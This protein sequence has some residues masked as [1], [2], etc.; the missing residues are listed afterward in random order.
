MD[1]EL[2]AQARLAGERLIEAE[3]DADVARADFHRAVRRLHLSGASLRQLAS[4]LKLSH[5]RI[6][7]IVEEAGGARRWRVRD[8]PV[9]GALACSFCG[10]TQPRTKVLVAGPGVWICD[11]CIK[12]AGTVMTSGRAAQTPLGPLSAVPEDVTDRRCSFCG[13]SRYQVSGLVISIDNPVGKS[14]EDASICAECLSLCQEI[15]AE[16]LSSSASSS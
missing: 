15:H 12:R 5:Q 2:L 8:Q 7:Q 16:R 4:E 14:G 13:K 9:T 3:H 10:R 11:R 6:H 1:Q